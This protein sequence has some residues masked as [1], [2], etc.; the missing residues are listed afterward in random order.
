MQWNAR[1]SIDNPNQLVDKVVEAVLH[2]QGIPFEHTSE[3]RSEYSYTKLW[4]QLGHYDREYLG[5]GASSHLKHGLSS[6][7]R[8]FACPHTSM[9]LKPVDLMRGVAELYSDL[10]IK[11][12]R[13]AGLTAYGE[14]KA[15]AFTI[16]LDKAQAILC[17]GKAPAPCLAGVRTQRKKKTRLVWM[18]PLEMT[19]IEACVARPLINYFS[20]TEGVM[21]F[22]QFSH[23]I[24]S[25]LRRSASSTRFH[26]SIDYSQFDSCVS[27]LLIHYAFNAFRS[28]FDL[29]DK[30]LENVTVGQAFDVIERYFI[31]TPIVMP[32]AMAK[33]PVMVTG[34]VGGVPSGSYFT[35]LVDSFANVALLYAC[36]S[37]FELALKDENVFVLGDDC[38]FFCNRDGGADLLQ[39]M[40]GF[41]ASLGFSVNQQK[42]SHGLSTDVVEYLGRH[43]HNGFPMRPMSEIVRGALYPEKY[44]RYSRDR[45]T[46]QAQA[47]AVVNSYLLTSYVEDPPVGVETFSSPYVVSPWMSSGYTQFLLR[48]GMVP[49]KVLT[50][51]IY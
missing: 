17:D 37:R 10:S 13:S 31:T 36:S 24:G 1:Q 16:G 6:A 51:A 47:L 48:E 41:L 15:Q 39:Q 14:S 33:F 45:G 2:Q 49:G 8:T 29:E 26:Y 42:G 18:Y 43:W 4:E 46:R 9:K 40:S 22:G 34:K 23:E 32:K 25:R 19:M 5:N 27:P 30:I 3:Y 35:Q 50:R 44:R 28:W 11:G 38:L 21:T 12:D 20:S 7:F